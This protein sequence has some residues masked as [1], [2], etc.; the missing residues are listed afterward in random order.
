MESEDE[1]SMECLPIQSVV[2]ASHISLLRL[3]RSVDFGVSINHGRHAEMS[4]LTRA[5]ELINPFI[6]DP[7]LTLCI[8]PAAAPP[9]AGG[10]LPGFSSCG[11]VWGQTVRLIG[12][13]DGQWMGVKGCRCG[14]N[15]LEEFT[16][17]EYPRFCAGNN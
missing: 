1:D 5:G 4:C 10:R 14:A 12:L 16:R 7:I 13:D 9:T 6:S 11:S 8:L 15:S 3:L 2:R 17:L